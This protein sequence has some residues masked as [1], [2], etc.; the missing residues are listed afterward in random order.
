MYKMPEAHFRVRSE[1]DVVLNSVVLWCRSN[2][3]VYIA[4]QEV[5]KSDG[6]HIHVIIDTNK[7]ISTFRQNFVKEFPSLKGNQSYS[8]KIFE[9][10]LDHNIRYVCKGTKTELPKLIYHSITLAEIID[11]HKRFWEENKKFLTEHGVPEDN[12]K[13]KKVVPF[14]ERIFNQLPVGIGA[15]YAALVNMYNPS[16]Y[17]KAEL[18][19]VRSVVIETVIKC[20]GKNAKCCDDHLL[21]KHINGVFV[22]CV[23]EYGNKDDLKRLKSLM[24]NRISQNLY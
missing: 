5:G 22:M 7:T 16:D 18:E 14:V 8:L 2:S 9:K 15:A 20:F 1:D 12:K 4:V 13:T 17:E 6:K 19:K 3:K 24:T 10:D 21:T 11:A 23:T